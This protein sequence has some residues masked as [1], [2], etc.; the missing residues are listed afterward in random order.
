IRE[1]ITLPGFMILMASAQLASLSISGFKPQLIV[2]IEGVLTK[3]DRIPPGE[4]ERWLRFIRNEVEPLENGWYCVKL[5]NSKSLDEGISDE[6]GLLQ[7]LRPFQLRFQKAIRA[8]APRFRPYER[9]L[10][11]SQEFPRFDFLTDEEN[12]SEVC[13]ASILDTIAAIYVD[14]VF[15]RAQLF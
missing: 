15:D 2:A 14:E 8:T 11:G 7:S 4:E 12:E 13:F 9:A 3:P 1:L 10:S 6:D 5:P